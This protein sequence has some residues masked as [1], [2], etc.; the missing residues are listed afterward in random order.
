MCKLRDKA[1]SEDNFSL[2]ENASRNIQRCEVE[3]DK[4]LETEN[5]LEN[6]SP[7]FSRA[8]P[9]AGKCSAACA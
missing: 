3:I 8:C 5:A 9:I 7:F 6:V 1:F 2:A 4:L